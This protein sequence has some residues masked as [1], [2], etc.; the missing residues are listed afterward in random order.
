M[1]RLEIKGN[2]VGLRVFE[3]LEIIT[4]KNATPESVPEVSKPHIPGQYLR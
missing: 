1:T 3:H 4:A 2:A